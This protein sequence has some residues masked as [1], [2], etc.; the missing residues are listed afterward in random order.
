MLLRRKFP[1]ARV[2]RMDASGLGSAGI[3]T[4]S[5]VSAVI[6]GLPLL[7]MP[8]DK[9]AAILSGAFGLLRQ[10]G[11]FYQFTYGPKC[12]VSRVVLDPLGLQAVRIGRALAN[13]PPAAVYRIE[14]KAPGSHKTS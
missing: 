3:L 12:P 7:G 2:L 11:A 4:L 8:N 1:Q 10:G 13:L 9:V 14:R 6:S 5:P